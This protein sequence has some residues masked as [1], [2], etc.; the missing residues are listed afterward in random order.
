MT[1]LKLSNLI[2]FKKGYKKEFIDAIRATSDLGIN[3]PQ[4]EKCKVKPI[5]RLESKELVD[6]LQQKMH[7]FGID[8]VAG[9][10]FAITIYIKPFIEYVLGCNVYCTMG[11][12]AFNRDRLFIHLLK[13]YSIQ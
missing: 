11:Y 13:I 10:C 9:Q 2:S 5:T 3:I 6:F 1:T 4:E 8:T 7:D 12:V